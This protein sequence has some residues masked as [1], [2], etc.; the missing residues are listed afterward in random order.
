MPCI[1]A[2]NKPDKEGGAHTLNGN[3]HLLMIFF[4]SFRQST[5]LTHVRQAIALE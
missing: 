4:F 1:Q 2:S 3:I 5:K